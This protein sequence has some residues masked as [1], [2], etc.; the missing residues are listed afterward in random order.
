MVIRRVI[1]T[2]RTALYKAIRKVRSSLRITLCHSGNR[3]LVYLRIPFRG[4]RARRWVPQD[5][6]NRMFLGGAKYVVRPWDLGSFERCTQR[7]AL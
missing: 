6:V 5:C 2:L 7:T 3:V 1:P 4:L